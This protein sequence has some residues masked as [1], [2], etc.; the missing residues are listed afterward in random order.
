MISG[1]FNVQAHERILFGRP[2]AEAVAAEVERFGAQRVFVLSTRSLEALADGPLQRIVEALGKRWAGTH[3]AMRA[4]TPREDVLAA[5]R[6]LRAANA[7]LLVAVGG[8]SVIDGAKAVQLCVWYGLQRPDEFDA[9][10]PALARTRRHAPPPLPAEPLRMIAVSTTL[11]AAEFTSI[12]GVTDTTSAT[13]QAFAHRLF[14]PRTVVL[15]PAATLHT[16]EWLL[17]ATGLR[18]VDHAVE[19]YCSPR[20]NPA[21]EAL[22]LQGLRLL[23]DAL[24]RIR[25]APD[26]LDARLA[27]QFG[28][29][30]AVAPVAAG[31]GTGASHGI[32]YV[33]GGTYGVP[34]GH[35]SC[36]ML[37]AVLRWNAEV[38]AERQR[39]L[40]AA[41]GSSA[42][43]ADAIADLVAGLGL[44]RRL[45]DVGM[46][47]DALDDIAR[48]A[49]DEEAVRNNPRRIERPEH[50][51]EILDLAW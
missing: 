49:V 2:A 42:P 50:V 39:A 4:H 40:S 31:V 36:V 11:S 17:L 44:P 43:A 26:D 22:S 1:Q 46:A 27:A 29:W 23:A 34:H 5:A 32:G 45:R 8:G 47:H 14:A 41:M 13:K 21:T 10:V 51:R 48:R 25:R 7:D 24:P 28:M 33:L 15:D 9:Y 38:N 3:T 37:P 30:Q 20:C 6:A 16:P 18:A 35:T 12:A 19:T